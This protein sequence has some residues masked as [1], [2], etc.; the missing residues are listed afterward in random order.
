M[1]ENYDG[2]M[3]IELEDGTVTTIKETLEKIDEEIELQRKYLRYG[4]LLE[5][6]KQTEA[7]QELIEGKYFEDEPERLK[8]ALVNP[9]VFKREMVENMMDMMSGIRYLKQF[10]IYV[11]MDAAGAQEK[12]DE[13]EAYRKEITRVQ[14]ESGIIDAE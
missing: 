6:L 3:G 11:E 12:I 13:S 2:A 8:Q 7:Y 1:S 10:F 4:K 5:E 14:S 9:S